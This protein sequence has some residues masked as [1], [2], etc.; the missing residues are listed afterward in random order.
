[1]KCLSA[2]CPDGDLKRL[3]VNL[4]PEALKLWSIEHQNANGSL[5]ALN[6]VKQSF[7]SLMKHFQ[8]IGYT[9]T[10]IGSK[11]QQDAIINDFCKN[12]KILLA[13]RQKEA[14]SIV[15]PPSLAETIINKIENIKF[16][17]RELNH[18]LGQTLFPNIIVRNA[19]PVTVKMCILF[20][21]LVTGLRSSELYQISLKELK[22]NR[23]ARTL[24]HNEKPIR[25]IVSFTR[26]QHHK[27]ERLGV[28]RFT[29]VILA[30]NVSGNLEPTT[31]GKAFAYLSKV[32][33]LRTKQVREE[34]D[35]PIP[36]TRQFIQ[37]RKPFPYTS[38]HLTDA[39]KNFT[40]SSPEIRR[41]IT[42]NAT[43]RTTIL[44]ASQQG[45]SNKQIRKLTAW[46]N[47]ETLKTYL[48]HNM[49]RFKCYQN[50]YPK[51]LESYFRLLFQVLDISKLEEDGHKITD[52]EKTMPKHFLD[53]DSGL[54]D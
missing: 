5:L 47:S 3:H 39:L 28:K 32:A 41:A 7:K 8:I 37:N 23:I 19:D 44:I 14:E 45:G 1:M 30:T 6:T 36:P 38:V 51:S 49:I 54:E 12:L 46:T 52:L 2:V 42:A 26:I 33:K 16:E 11:F 31:L 43:R 50:K 48:G 25:A 27:T 40:K 17:S 34:W 53:V 29:P 9:E 20:V 15:W 24:K 13:D 21:M 35:A 18:P 10:N 4:L 22:Q